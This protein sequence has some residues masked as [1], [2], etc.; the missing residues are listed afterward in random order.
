MAGIDHSSQLAISP[1]HT[2]SPRILIQWFMRLD[3]TL[4]AYVVNGGLRKE[5]AQFFFTN[6]VEGNSILSQYK[7]EKIIREAKLFKMQ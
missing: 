3:D 5:V 2:T 1:V 6:K 4:V 7:K